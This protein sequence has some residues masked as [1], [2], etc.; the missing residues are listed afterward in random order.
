LVHRLLLA[1]VAASDWW[2]GG[3]TNTAL[4]N[5]QDLS[6]LCAHINTRN[7]A[8]QRAQRD[9]QTLFQ[10]LY[11]RNRPVSDPR[12]VVDAVIFS[13][14]ENGFLV[15]IPVYA[16]KGPV[17]LENKEKEV[18]YCGRLG[19]VWQKGLVTKKE[20]FVK[21][22]TIEG[23]NMFRLFDHITVGIQLKGSEAHANTLS[24]SL[25]DKQPWRSGSVDST[26]ANNSEERVNFLQAARDEQEERLGEDEEGMMEVEDRPK[27]EKVNMYHFFQQMRQIGVTP[28]GTD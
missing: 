20:T 13:L 5:N 3:L 19:P 17:Y 11:F 4:L 8:A 14:R 2:A 15:Y 27:K 22:E 24:L 26:D 18:L 16:I 10:T 9:S 23:T 7:R 6:E 21:V 28:I 1:A 12:C 25:L